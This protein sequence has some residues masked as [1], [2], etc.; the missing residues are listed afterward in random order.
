MSAES[1]P[2]GPVKPRRQPLLGSGREELG[3]AAILL[4]AM[5]RWLDARGVERVYGPDLMREISTH[6]GLSP[7]QFWRLV[8]ANPGLN[9]VGR[10]CP[11]FDALTPIGCRNGCPDHAAAPALCGFSD[12]QKLALRTVTCTAR[13][14]NGLQSNRRRI[15]ASQKARKGYSPPSCWAC[16]GSRQGAKPYHPCAVFT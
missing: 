9:V 7:L 11:P 3:R 16:M 10:L 2:S 13:R 8:A 15:L 5:S 6:S 14:V 1:S 12:A 4:V